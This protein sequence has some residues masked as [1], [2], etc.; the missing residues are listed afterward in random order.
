VSDQ[1]EGIPADGDPGHGR[2]DP[3]AAGQHDGT[4]TGSDAPVGSVGEEA[5]KLFGALSDWAREQGHDYAGTAS[6]AADALGGVL[7]DVNEHLATDSAECRYCPVCQVVHVVRRTSPE[8]RTHLVQ[9]ATS[10]MQAAAGLLATRTDT[11][12]RPGVERIDLD[13]D[14][15]WDDQ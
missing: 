13:G 4:A 8:V 3:R 14:G 12:P 7:H 1:R 6:G 5:V 2:D 11:Q 10:L 15:G 9:A